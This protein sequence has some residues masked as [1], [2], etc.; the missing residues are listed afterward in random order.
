M[1]FLQD[2]IDICGR[3]EPRSLFTGFRKTETGI[4]YLFG[5]CHPVERTVGFLDGGRFFLDEPAAFTLPEFM[6]QLGIQLG[7]V[8]RRDTV[9]RC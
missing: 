3:Q 5:R 4:D 9:D 7:M 2:S 6:Q 8:N 1:L